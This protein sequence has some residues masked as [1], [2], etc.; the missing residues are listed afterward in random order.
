MQIISGPELLQLTEA[1]A[2]LLDGEEW[3]PKLPPAPRPACAPRYSCG[4]PATYGHILPWVASEDMRA[5]LACDRCDP[6]GY[7]FKLD[8]YLC[9]ERYNARQHISEKRLGARAVE[10]VDAAIMKAAR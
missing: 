2:E 6:G 5:E 8:R 1:E 10:V 3:P 9:G 4:K 7:H